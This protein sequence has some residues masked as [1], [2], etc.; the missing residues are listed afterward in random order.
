MMYYIGLTFRTCI[1]DHWLFGTIKREP[2]TYMQ[3]I[4]S[5]LFNFSNYQYLTMMCVMAL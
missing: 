5:S 4:S 3:L 1:Y 2:M